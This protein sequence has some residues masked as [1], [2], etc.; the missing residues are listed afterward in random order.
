MENNP[1]TDNR[2]DKIIMMMKKVTVMVCGFTMMAVLAACSNAVPSQQTESKKTIEQEASEKVSD[3]SVG[4]WKNNQGSLKINDN[5]EAKVAF[6][7]ATEGLDGYKYEV[8][9]YLGSQVVQGTNYAYF[10]KGTP[11]VPEAEVEY[12]I[13]NIYEDLEGNAEITG[14][15]E[16]E[17]TAETENSEE[18]SGK[19]TPNPFTEVSTLS[20]ACAITGFDLTVPEAPVEY[21]NRIIRVMDQTMI[22][23]IFVNKANKTDAGQDEGYRIRKAEG[24]EDVSGDYNE[25]AD[26]YTETINGNEVTLKGN[27]ESVSVAIWSADGC[28]YAVD[29]QDHPLSKEAMTEVI[30]TIK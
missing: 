17:L 22:E 20:E 23:V 13:L 5:R 6:E 7:K 19:Q 11:V 21:P 8:I 3:E 12:L 26:I 14:N 18:T 29:A 2:K 24:V 10:C 25:Y 27:D 15:K 4:G 28:T 1:D 9:A 30:S 16:I